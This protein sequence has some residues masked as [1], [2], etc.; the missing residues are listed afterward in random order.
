MTAL[1]GITHAHV[2]DDRLKDFLYD[3]HFR[4]ISNGYNTS[5]KFV[6]DL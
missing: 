3:N 4:N 5:M 2:M 6:S 1:T